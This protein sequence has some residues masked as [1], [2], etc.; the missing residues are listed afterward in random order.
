MR[1]MSVLI[2][3][4]MIAAMVITLYAQQRDIMPIMKEVGATAVPMFKNIG[5]GTAPAADV[6]KDAEKL[7]GLFKEAGGFMKTQKAEKGIGY[8]KDAEAAAGDIAKAA[9]ANDMAAVKAGS[10]KLKAQ[11]KACHDVHREQ[12]PDKTFKFKP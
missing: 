7:Q 3:V 8:A 5:G 9:K 6:Q 4:C 11:C 12:L 2:G 10:D 1:R